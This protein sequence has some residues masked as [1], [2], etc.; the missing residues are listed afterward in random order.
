MP[1]TLDTTA[2]EPT[3]RQLLD[4][5]ITAVRE[6]ATAQVAVDHA[7]DALAAAETNHAAVYA[8]ATRAGWSDTELKNIGLTAPARRTPGRPRRPR[9]NG[10]RTPASQSLNDATESADLDAY[11]NRNGG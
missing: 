8:T 6:L 2:V 7:R 4:A 1:D 3:A 10:S 11:Q 9:A 5:R